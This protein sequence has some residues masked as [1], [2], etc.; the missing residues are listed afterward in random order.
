MDLR[1]D[2]VKIVYPFGPVKIKVKR[3]KGG[4]VIFPWNC[5]P[6]GVV[7]VPYVYRNID[8]I[9]DNVQASRPR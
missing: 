2:L 3:R 6:G 7:Y 1:N 4:G 5:R 8:W 9:G